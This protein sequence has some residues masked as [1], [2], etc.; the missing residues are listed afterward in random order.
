MPSER[1][2]PPESSTKIYETGEVLVVPTPVHDCFS[3]FRYQNASYIVLLDR[4]LKNGQPGFQEELGRL[5]MVEVAR[6]PRAPGT[7]AEEVRILR[8]ILVRQKP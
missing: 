5:G 1:L 8:R 3:Y 2:Q 6:F 4:Q 7:S